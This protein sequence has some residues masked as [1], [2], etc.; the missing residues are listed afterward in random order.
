MVPSPYSQGG[1]GT[2]VNTWLRSFL[3]TLHFSFAE[4]RVGWKADQKKAEVTELRKSISYLSVIG[5]NNEVFFQLKHRLMALL[6][7]YVLQKKFE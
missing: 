7:K 4:L 1:R 5:G 2:T 3:L 6:V